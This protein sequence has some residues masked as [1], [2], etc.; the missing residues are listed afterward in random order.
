MPQFLAAPL[1]QFA[2]F[3]TDFIVYHYDNE[4]SLLY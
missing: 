3:Y 2:L 4:I 1:T